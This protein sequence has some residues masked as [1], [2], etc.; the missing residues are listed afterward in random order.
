MYTEVATRL[1]LD[2]QAEVSRPVSMEGANAASFDVT[3]YEVNPTPSTVLFRLQ[4]SNDLDNWVDQGSLQNKNVVGYFTF[5]LVPNI[6]TAYIRL[7]YATSAKA[8]INA[9][10]YTFEE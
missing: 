4:G 6:D 10:I 3:I 1:V 7:T 5:P 8:A 9:G 2:N